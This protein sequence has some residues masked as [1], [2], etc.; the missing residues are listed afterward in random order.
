MLTKREINRLH[1]AVK[2][3]LSEKNFYS[4]IAIASRVLGKD[5]EFMPLRQ[6]YSDFYGFSGCPAS[7]NDK[8]DRALAL[9]LFAEVQEL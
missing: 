6:C 3:I 9:L 5:T 2:R 4:C 1:R 7:F 8:N